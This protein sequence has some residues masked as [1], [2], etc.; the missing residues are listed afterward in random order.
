MTPLNVLKKKPSKALICKKKIE[1][2]HHVHAPKLWQTYKVLSNHEVYPHH[3]YNIYTLKKTIANL[4][5]LG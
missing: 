1:K 4:I 3:L 5:F 2:L